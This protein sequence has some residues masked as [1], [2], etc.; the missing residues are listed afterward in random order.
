MP[1]KSYGST[2]TLVFYIHY[3][4]FYGDKK[5]TVREKGRAIVALLANR[6]W[7]EEKGANFPVGDISLRF[8]LSSFYTFYRLDS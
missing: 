7:G 8:T 5:L 4:S 1:P 6:W 3:F 2:E